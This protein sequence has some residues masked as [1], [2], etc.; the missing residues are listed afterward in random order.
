[1]TV[2]APLV[3]AGVVVCLDLWVLADAR[4]WARQGTPVVFRIGSVTVGTP[5]AWAAACLLLFVI[6]VP[7]YVVARN[8]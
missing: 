3:I 2:L 7:I 8:S 6:F 1:M 5:E 4:R